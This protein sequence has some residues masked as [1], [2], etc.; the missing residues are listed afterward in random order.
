[1]R[2]RRLQIRA[3]RLLDRVPLR[4][5]QKLHL[6]TFL[7]GGLCGLA[8]VAFHWLLEALQNGIIYRVAADAGALAGATALLLIPALGRAGRRVPVF[9]S[10][11]PRRGAAEYPRSRRPSCSRVDGSR[12]E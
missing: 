6:L 12:P 2:W 7:I 10:T 5:S 11:L 4:E 1:M 3:R 9:T 8:A